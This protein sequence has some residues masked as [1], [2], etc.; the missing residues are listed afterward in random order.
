[1]AE[2]QEVPQDKRRRDTDTPLG[3]TARILALMYT[4]G[5][6][7]LIISL[8]WKGIPEDNKDVVN[9]LVGIL[10]IIQTGIINYY[11][12]GSKAVDAA[13]RAGVS[14]RAQ[15]DAVIQDIAKAVPAVIPTLVKQPDG[16]NNETTVTK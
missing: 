5:Y 12:G 6:F 15:A 14:G 3:D 8:M 2:E 13:Q 10:S 7:V 4:L 11:F 1:M 9:T 16:V